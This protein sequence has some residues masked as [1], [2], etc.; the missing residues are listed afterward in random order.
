[1]SACS[2]LSG[3]SMIVFDAIFHVS[4]EY[5]VTTRFLTIPA[6]PRP[7]RVYIVLDFSKEWLIHQQRGCYLD[8]YADLKFLVAAL[9]PKLTLF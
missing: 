1:M 6:S 8:P 9:A 7:S 4:V 2:I 5:R 3:G